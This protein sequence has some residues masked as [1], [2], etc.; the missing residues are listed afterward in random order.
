MHRPKYTPAQVFRRTPEQRA[1]QELSWH[2]PDQ[3]FFAAGACHILAWEFVARHPSYRIVALQRVGDEYPSHVIAT[4][5]TW[6]FDHDGWTP[7]AEL[8]AVTADH[9]PGASW[10][11]LAITTDLEEFCRAHWHRPPEGFFQDPRPRARAYLERFPAS[12]AG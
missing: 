9:E 3:A 8:L 10:E 11:V 4:D 12:P 7:E 6:A 5:G 1:D 2:R